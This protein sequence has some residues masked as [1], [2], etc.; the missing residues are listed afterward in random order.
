MNDT[1][2]KQY[3]VLSHTDITHM[4]LIKNKAEELLDAINSRPNDASIDS[5]MIALAKTNLEQA[6]MWAIK[7]IT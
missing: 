1:F 2:R 5:R 7:A 6:V 3:K 4:D